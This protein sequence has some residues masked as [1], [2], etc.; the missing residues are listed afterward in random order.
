MRFSTVS[1][2]IALLGGAPLTAQ[3]PQVAAPRIKQLGTRGAYGAGIILAASRQLTFEL[4][5]PAHV[6]VLRVEPDGSIEPVLAAASDTATP[7]AGG[8]HTVEAAPAGALA[9]SGSVEKPR[10]PVM[11]SAQGVAR[12]GVAVFKRATGD[13]PEPPPMA[14]WL[15]IVS[16]A[17]LTADEV[18]KRLERMPLNFPTIQ[19]EV[20]KLA[21]ELTRGRTRWW[22][23]LYTA[24][25]P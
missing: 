24:V 5:D 19:V 20:E 21:R 2:L 14:Y 4:A 15:L 22:T 13:D 8:R 6:V 11:R 25:A 23:A 7:L 9:T 10:E 3:E 16:D 1:S 17:R 12:E 18:Q